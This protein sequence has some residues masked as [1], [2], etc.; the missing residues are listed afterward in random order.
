MPDTLQALGVLV[1]ALLPGALYVWAFERQ[2]GRWGIGLSD[3]AL[4]FIGGSAMFHAAAAPLS[5]GLWA[6]HWDAVRSARP[7]S[8]WLWLVPMLYVALPWAGGALGRDDAGLP[9]VQPGGLLIR[10][11]EVEFLEFIDA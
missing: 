9:T 8:W 4:R 2:V 5:Y 10:W 1:I 11:E 6:D 3:R 7:V